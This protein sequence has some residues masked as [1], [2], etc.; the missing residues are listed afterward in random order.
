MS[1][2]TIKYEIAAGCLVYDVVRLESQKERARLYSDLQTRRV[3]ARVDDLLSQA[4]DSN[5]KTV[6]FFS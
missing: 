5:D 2:A 4:Q 3:L 1:M 6:L